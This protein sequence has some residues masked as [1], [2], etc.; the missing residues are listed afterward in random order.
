MAPR[1][2]PKDP[3]NDTPAKR[4]GTQPARESRDWC[5]LWALIASGPAH[6]AYG[7][8]QSLPEDLLVRITS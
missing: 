8:L 2:L 4:R 7:G 5:G 6:A 3:F 1:S